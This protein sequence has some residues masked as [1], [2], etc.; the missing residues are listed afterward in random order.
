MC[1]QWSPAKS[2]GRST[3]EK[4][5][6]MQENEETND[7]KQVESVFTFENEKQQLGK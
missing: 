3:K 2:R 6:K 1:G 7:E 4:K 5:W